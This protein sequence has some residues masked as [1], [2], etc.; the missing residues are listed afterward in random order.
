[1]IAFRANYEKPT[2]IQAQAI[3]AIMA[4]NDLIGIA[5]TGSGKTV[6]FLLPMLRQIMDQRPLD[7]GEGPIGEKKRR[8]LLRKEAQAV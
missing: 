5:K 8:V 1:M 7:S 2:I 4:G 3:P 6:A